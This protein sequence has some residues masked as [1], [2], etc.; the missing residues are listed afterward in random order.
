[1]DEE[2]YLGKLFDISCVLKDYSD[3]LQ[4]KLRCPSQ[5]VDGYEGVFLD[6][7][8][9]HRENINGT[10]ILMQCLLENSFIK[11]PL[12]AVLRSLMAD[13]L[14]S[15]YLYT[16]FVPSETKQITL[17]NEIRCLD[18]EYQ[19]FQKEVAEIEAKEISKCDIKEREQIHG[20]SDKALFSRFMLQ[21]KMLSEKKKYEHIK[22]KMPDT[23]MCQ[24]AKQCF[25]YN[26]FFTQYYHYNPMGGLIG[27]T[28]S[29]EEME[30]FYKAIIYSISAF[31]FIFPVIGRFF[32]KELAEKVKKNLNLLIAQYRSL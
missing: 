30:I 18:M 17:E 21:G 4:K 29:Q 23:D 28:F 13:S 8:I 27:R 20:S 11:I 1:M 12:A 31:R 7:A 26:K 16:L 5:K 22:E 3:Y 24:L 15:L 6:L 32:P 25:V 2:K 10:L 9:R 14:T 19:R